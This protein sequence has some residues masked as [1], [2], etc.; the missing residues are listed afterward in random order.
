MN[1]EASSSDSENSS[2]RE[3][4]FAVSVDQFNGPIDLL[5]HLVKKNEL[6][7][8]KVSLAYVADQY[9]Q[10]LERMRDLDLEVAGEFLVIAATLLSIKSS[11]LLAEPVE[12]E[13]DE[14]GNLLDPHEEL[15][16][17]LKEAAIYKEGAALLGERP[18]LD[19]DVFAPKSKLSKLPT[20]PETFT[21]HDP[22]LLGVAFKKLIEKKGLEDVSYE[23][24]LDS[25]SIVDR[26]MQVLEILQKSA[27]GHTFEELVGETVTK[28]IVVGTFVALLE[29]CKRQVI[30]VRQAGGEMG[31]EIIVQLKQTEELSVEGLQSEFDSDNVNGD[32][33]N[34]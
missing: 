31:D 6:E 12:F 10:C 16:M 2:F 7:I 14:E 18:L 34:I 33:A 24:V 27:K 11:V 22:Y 1:S 23:V 32:V 15:L 29:L 13:F 5:L 25:V 19:F 8:E 28:G 9:V 17:R 3:V 20:P 30:S 26:M 21:E 4:P